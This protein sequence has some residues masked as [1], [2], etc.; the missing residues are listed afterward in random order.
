MSLPA[1]LEPIGD[2]ADGPVLVTGGSF[3]SEPSAWMAAHRA[4]IHAVLER[5]RAA[6]FRGFAIDTVDRFQACLTA[7]QTDLLPYSERSTPRSV[8]QG[9]VYTSTEYPRTA[10]I[11]MHNENS[12]SLTWPRRII[13]CSLSVAEQGG[14]TPI[15]DSRAVFQRLDGHVRAAFLDKKVMYIRNYGQG[16]DLPWQTVFQTEHRHEVEAYCHAHDIGYEWFDDGAGLSTRQIRPAALCHRPTNERVWFNQAHLFH[17]SSLEP[18]LRQALC[19]VFPPDRLPRHATYG[20][21]TAIEDDVLDEI[22]DVYSAVR[23]PIDWQKGDLLLLDNLFYAHGRLPFVGGRKVVV[24][25]DTR[26]GAD[27]VPL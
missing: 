7:L 20:D 27:T 23:V 3:D 11:P 12:Y 8:V 25:M 10:E 15:A 14:A 19:D 16:V 24:A 18:A 17:V 2:R 22:R 26:G 21:G 9:Q 13:F 5:H 1:H 4:E 6:L